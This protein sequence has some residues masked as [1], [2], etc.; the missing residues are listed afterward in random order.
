M[1]YERVWGKRAPKIMIKGMEPTGDEGTIGHRNGC[2][3]SSH[4]VRIGTIAVN[5]AVACDS[6]HF[7][8]VNLWWRV[9][10]HDVI[11]A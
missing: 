2:S 11:A 7:L 8:E 1:Q 6:W 3:I 4:L 9:A 10:A 5:V